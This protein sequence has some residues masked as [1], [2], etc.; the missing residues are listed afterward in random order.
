MYEE[1]YAKFMMA[2]MII[3]IVIIS[4]LI[5]AV[6]NLPEEKIK[7]FKDE[8]IV[9]EEEGYIDVYKNQNTL[10]IE[11]KKMMEQHLQQLYL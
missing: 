3:G 7:V 10:T 4:A 11:K 8:Q 1:T 2:L 6:P 5:I 9:Y